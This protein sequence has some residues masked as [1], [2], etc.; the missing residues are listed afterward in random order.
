VWFEWGFILILVAFSGIL[1]SLVSTISKNNV[2]TKVSAIVVFIG[3]F[4]GAFVWTLTGLAIRFNTPADIC[5][6]IGAIATATI[7]GVP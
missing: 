4:L 3:N 7:D 5:S 1:L 6:G 2:L